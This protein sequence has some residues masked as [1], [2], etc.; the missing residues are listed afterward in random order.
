MTERRTVSVSGFK[1][2]WVLKSY[3]PHMCHFVYKTEGGQEGDFLNNF[4][5]DV[6]V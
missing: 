1:Y 6:I 3:L 4:E 2:N 5:D